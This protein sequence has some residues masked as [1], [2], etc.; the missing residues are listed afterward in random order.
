MTFPGVPIHPAELFGEYDYTAA[1][2]YC[3]M[4]KTWLLLLSEPTTA[5]AKLVPAEPQRACVH[6]LAQTSSAILIDT[7]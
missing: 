1:G 5:H 3:V 6:E 7:C 2:G 4:W